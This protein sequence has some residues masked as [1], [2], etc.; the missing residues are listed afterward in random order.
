M[1]SFSLFALS[2]MT[3]ATLVVAKRIENRSGKR[4][5]L[6]RAISMGDTHIRDLYHR[7]LDFYSEGKDKSLFFIKKQLPLKV[8][9]GLT[10]AQTLVQEKL[11]SRLGNVRN[12]RL[13]KRR[14]SLSEFFKNIS[15]V[16]KGAGEIN[17]HIYQPE[18]SV[19]RP[20][21]PAPLP[22]PLA[23][24]ITP[25][26]TAVTFSRPAPTLNTVE[27][28]EP[29]VKKKVA[30]RK[31]RVARTAVKKAPVIRK[32]RLKVVQLTDEPTEVL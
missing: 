4:F 10:K 25:P 1:I 11:E 26:T 13:L 5:F 21:E 18:Q 6:L 14:E 12:S 7:G 29:V 15:E 19:T 28:V 2:G 23:V 8:K 3:L 24:R 22:E 27:T 9:K 17:G 31:P 32:R 16:E 20:A 30:T